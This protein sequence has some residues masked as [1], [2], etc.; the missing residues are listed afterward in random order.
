MGS[1]TFRAIFSQT[2]LATL[3]SFEASHGK[4]HLR[5]DSSTRSPDAEAVAMTSAPYHHAMPC[6]WSFCRLPEATHGFQVALSHARLIVPFP[7]GLPDF[8]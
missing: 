5:R 8:S 6:H 7:A 3:I 4:D 2:H 1:A